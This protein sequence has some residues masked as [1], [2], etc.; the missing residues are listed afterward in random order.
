MDGEARGGRMAA[1]WCSDAGGR[2]G[3]ERDDSGD[4]GPPSTGWLP[5]EEEEAEAVRRDTSGELGAAQGGGDWRGKAAA[6]RCTG[7]SKEE[8]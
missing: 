5:R 7:S 4:G 1:Q 2:G 3:E 6:R 8:S